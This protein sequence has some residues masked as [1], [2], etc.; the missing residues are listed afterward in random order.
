MIEF[1]QHKSLEDLFK[2][3]WM[4]VGTWSN[5]CLM[6]GRAGERIIYNKITEEII[7]RYSTEIKK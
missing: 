2:D 7:I 5:D 1:I 3:K 4:P 6:L